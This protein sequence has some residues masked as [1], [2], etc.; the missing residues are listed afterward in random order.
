MG[1]R[2]YPTKA[3]IAILQCMAENGGR[4]VIE[5]GQRWAKYF[6][7]HALIFGQALHSLLQNRW[8]TSKGQNAPRSY[9]WTVAGRD[10]YRNG[11]YIHESRTAYWLDQTKPDPA[12]PDEEAKALSDSGCPGPG[13]PLD[14]PGRRQPRKPPHGA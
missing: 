14:D 7:G 4:A 1:R 9:S 13:R 8:I 5:T 3:Q 6:P 2:R 12:P 11:W 10:A